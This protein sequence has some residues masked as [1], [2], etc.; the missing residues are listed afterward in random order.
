MTLD[1]PGRPKS[2][3]DIVGNRNGTGENEWTKIR[4]SVKISVTCLGPDELEGD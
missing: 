1:F 4:T 2:T 3:S